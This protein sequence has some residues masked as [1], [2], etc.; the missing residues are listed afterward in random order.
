LHMLSKNS[1]S[2]KKTLARTWIARGLSEMC[3]LGLILAP[4]DIGCTAARCMRCREA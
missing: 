3:G 1:S 2:S 4:I